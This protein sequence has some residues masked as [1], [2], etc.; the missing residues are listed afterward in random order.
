ME[1]YLQQSKVATTPKI[2]GKVIVENDVRLS[3]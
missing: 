1:R 3:D 2:K